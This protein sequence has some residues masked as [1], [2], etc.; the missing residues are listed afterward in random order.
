MTGR[1]VFLSMQKRHN[2][3]I[4]SFGEALAGDYLIR[5]GYKILDKNAK[6]SYKEVDIIAEKDGWTIF[7]EV[8][9]RTSSVYGGASEALT[10]RKI[11]H[12]KRAISIYARKHSGLN[13]DFVRADLIA[14][15]INR[16][17]KT[18][19]IKHYQE[20]F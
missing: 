6:Q 9:T 3:D 11:S 12:I 4:G 19:K 14:I 16:E 15:D 5:K 18:A 17:K 13:Y 7:V 8:K 1:F 10:A 2:K 20:I